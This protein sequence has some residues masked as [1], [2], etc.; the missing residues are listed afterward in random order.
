MEENKEVMINDET[1]EKKEDSKEIKLSFKPSMLCLYIAFA[2][3]ALFALYEIIIAY[4][5][6]TSV[7]RGIA[8]TFLYPAAIGGFVLSVF[9]QRK[10]DINV[11]TSMVTMLVVIMSL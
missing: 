1:E 5:G 2:T 6:T 4:T 3:L 11:F 10:F 7:V 9:K 8:R